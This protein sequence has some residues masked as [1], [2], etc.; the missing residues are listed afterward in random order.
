MKLIRT[1]HPVGH[2]AFY[3]ERFYTDEDAQPYFTVVFDCGR[4]ETAKRGWSYPRYEKAMKTYVQNE[5]GLKA[6][7]RI[8]MLFISHFHTDHILGIDYLL[9][10]YKVGKIII[11]AI[12]SDVIFDSINSAQ[13]SVARFTAITDLIGELQGEY[14]ERVCTVDIQEDNFDAE[15]FTE[16]DIQNGGINGMHSITRGTV[17]KFGG[18]Y[19]KPYYKVDRVKERSL[20]KKLKAKFPEIFDVRNQVSIDKLCEKFKAVGAAPFKAIYTDVFG[21][22]KHNSYSLTLYSGMYCEKVCHKGCHI[23]ANEKVVN[24]QLCTC[25]CLYMGDYE[26]L[27]DRQK[28]IMRYYSKEW[29]NIGI[30]QVP[31]HGSEH[32]SDNGLYKDRRRICIISADSNDKYEHPDQIVLDAIVS[33]HSLPVIVSEYQKTKLCFMIQIFE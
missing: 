5:S 26:A 3:T 8:D 21:E 24:F 4:F 16:I 31:H 32:N 33:S 2:G 17:L 9:K 18:W 10:N 27:G 30:I 28:L 20:N 15:D 22:N 12:T 6:G 29:N 1:F 19:Y 25:N 11:P 7:E 13:K 23:K 14:S